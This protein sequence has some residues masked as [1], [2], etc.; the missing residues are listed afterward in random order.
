MISCDAKKHES[1]P[2]SFIVLRSIFHNSKAIWIRTAPTF[3]VYGT[4]RITFLSLENQSRDRSSPARP[5][6]AARDGWASNSLHRR[7]NIIIGQVERPIDTS[8]P[9]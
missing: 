5:N 9:D 8:L 4:P 1:I 7:V 2:P 6:L 3:T